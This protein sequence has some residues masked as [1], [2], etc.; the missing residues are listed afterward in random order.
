MKG[1]R[2]TVCV[3]GPRKPLSLKSKPAPDF[4]EV[5]YTI[6]HY[7]SDTDLNLAIKL[8]NPNIFI[9]Y[10]PWQQFKT[11]ALAP[12]DIRKRWI[13]V[14]PL[15]DCDLGQLVMARYMENVLVKDRDNPKVSIFT[16]AYNSGS[17]IFRPLRSI[18]EQTYRNIEWVI[19]D[20]GSDSENSKILDTLP[21]FDNRIQVYK[22][23]QRSG[24]IGEVKKRAC[25]LCTGEILI[26]ID[27]DDEFTITCIDDIVKA[28]KN[29]PEASFAYTDCAEVFEDNRNFEY[30]PGW[31]L[32]FGS[33]RD[34][35]Y[36]SKQY[37][38]TNYPPINAKTIRHIV[39]CPNHARAWR[40][41]FYDRIDGHN[42]QIHVADD[43]ELMLRSFLFTR[44]IHIRKFGYIQYKSSTSQTNVR[45][46]EIQRLV[47]YFKEYYD[48]AIHNRCVQLGD[49]DTIVW[50]GN[51]SNLA[52]GAASDFKPLSLSYP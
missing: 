33:Y 42:P 16:A 47:R 35:L 7:E 6:V 31:G 40:K 36:R 11:L 50:N 19:M 12:F 29:H 43:Y 22:S 46:R 5:D 17:K 30:P 48:A 3:F 27:H 34:E 45:N 51:T 44:V 49:E 1:E 8:W 13:D 15:N 41:S 37:R 24:R 38:V 39:G 10:G 14:S 21:A 28:F 2:I 25:G 18:V 4:E 52:L 9:T 32:G 23:T 20:D 26:E